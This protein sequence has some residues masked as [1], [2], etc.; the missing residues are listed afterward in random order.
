MKRSNKCAIRYAAIEFIPITTRGNAHFLCPLTSI[1]QLKPASNRKQAQRQISTII[2]DK[3]LGSRKQIEEPLIEC[4]PEIAVLV[5]VRGEARVLM[6][7]PGL[8]HAD[9][10]IIESGTRRGIQRPSQPVAG[11]DRAQGNP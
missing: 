9:R 10:L 1:T 6:I 5:P 8:R 2:G 4:I 3:R 7:L 11:E